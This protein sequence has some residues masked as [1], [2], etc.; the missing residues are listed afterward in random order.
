[1]FTKNRKNLQVQKP[2]PLIDY[3]TYVLDFEER[4]F[5]SVGI[6]ASS[7]FNVGVGEGFGIVI[8]I[9]TAKRNIDIRYELLNRI[10]SM[11]GD[12]LSVIPESHPSHSIFPPLKQA[13]GISDLLLIEE[14]TDV[15]ESTLPSSITLTTD[16]D[17]GA[18]GN[19]AVVARAL[20]RKKRS[21]RCDVI[22][23]ES[24]THPECYVLLN[25]EDLLSL[26]KLKYCIRDS[27]TRKT[28]ITLPAIV[29]QASCMVR[30]LETTY[31]HNPTMDEET[32]SCIENMRGDFK[33]SIA[34]DEGCSN[35]GNDE[36]VVGCRGGVMLEH[37]CS[38][39]SGN[40]G[41]GGEYEVSISFPVTTVARASE[42]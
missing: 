39:I 26:Q 11:M 2:S 12:I 30:Y 21:K 19:G 24:R 13:R 27:V 18:N 22:S 29:K 6:V 15:M 32:K 8:R 4:K 20:V 3:T 14:S 25:R 40:E 17:N 42:I 33:H 38:P 31:G 16:I 23:I 5:L 7:K 41:V 10:F 28:L 34:Q 9:L 1:M 35:P 36:G 37:F